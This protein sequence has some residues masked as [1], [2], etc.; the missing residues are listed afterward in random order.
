VLED[1]GLLFQ[2]VFGAHG[3]LSQKL[4]LVVIIELLHDS[5]SPWL[6]HRNEPGLSFVVKAQSDKGS[7]SSGITPATKE[8]HLVI[9]LE[10]LGDSQS[11]PDVPEAVDHTLSTLGKNRFDSTAASAHIDYVQAV[12]S[13]WAL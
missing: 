2:F 8:R 6:V 11:L 4:L 12:E 7:H 5:I 1:K 9:N 3:D 10:V 13:D